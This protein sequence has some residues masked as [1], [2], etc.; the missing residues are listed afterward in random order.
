MG[1]VWWIEDATLLLHPG[2]YLGQDASSSPEVEV[3]A[4]AVEFFVDVVVLQG[5]ELVFDHLR[6]TGR[7]DFVVGAMYK[8][9]RKPT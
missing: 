5:E 8:V 9:R 6:K 2:V 1:D 4:D 7:D 3:V